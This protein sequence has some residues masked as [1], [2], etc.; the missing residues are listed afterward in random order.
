MSS[1][2]NGFCGG[3][4]IG[5]ENWMNECFQV[6]HSRF[7]GRRRR[8]LGHHTFSCGIEER[9]DD[10][11]TQHEGPGRNG[12]RSGL[13]GKMKTYWS[14][15]REHSCLDSKTWWGRFCTQSSV[16]SGASEET[17]DEELSSQI[18][19]LRSQGELHSSEH[20]VA[21]QYSKK[22]N[23]DGITIVKM[24]EDKEMEEFNDGGAREK[25]LDARN[26]S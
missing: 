22:T 3:I 6:A 2:N 13:G 1:E 14:D 15:R 8:K 9:R 11:M 17:S 20:V 7:E 19:W 26:T 23:K 25:F 4:W 21:Y 24:R 10:Q 12:W 5:I 16:L 18:S